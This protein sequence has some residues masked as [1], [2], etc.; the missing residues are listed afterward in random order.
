M[1]NLNKNLDSDLLDDGLHIEG[2]WWLEY[3]RDEDGMFIIRVYD[4]DQEFYAQ[5]ES[6]N[7]KDAFKHALHYADPILN[8]FLFD[9]DAF[10][11]QQLHK[12]EWE[13]SS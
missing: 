9:E 10:S 11:W 12:P 13:E 6:P 4:K 1:N 3:G 2:N 7:L 8:T 5:I